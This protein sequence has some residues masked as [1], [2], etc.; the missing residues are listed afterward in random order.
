[1]PSAAAARE[2]G[3]RP[4]AGTSATVARALRL[5]DNGEIDGSDMARRP[6]GSAWARATCAACSPGI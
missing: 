3:F 6:P 2:A 4:W 5:I 1:V